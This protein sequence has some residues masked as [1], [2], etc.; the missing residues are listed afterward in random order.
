[1]SKA[2][3]IFKSFEEQEM[4]FLKYF[5]ELTPS[6]RL[7]ALAKLQKK[8]N[9]DNGPSSKKITILKHFIYGY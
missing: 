6:E 4:F 9:P 8:N 1:M 3:R 5:A 7:Q 2:I